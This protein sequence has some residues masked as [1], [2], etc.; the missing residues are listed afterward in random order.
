MSANLSLAIRG[1]LRAYAEA[2]AK[3]A[4]RI[5]TT[6]VRRAASRTAKG[7]QRQ[8]KSAFEDQ[9]KGGRTL[10]NAIR[11]KSIP[12]SG[13]S[14]DTVARVYSKAKYGASNNR[15]RAAFDLASL[16]ETAGTVFAATKTWLAIPTGQAPQRGGQG[17]SRQAQPSESGL[18]L[19]FVP[20][21]SFRALLV[22]DDPGRPRG[23][24]PVVMYVLVKQS[25]RRR[26]LDPGRAH[27]QSL[28][29]SFSDFQQLWARHDAELRARFGRGLET[30]NE[31]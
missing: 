11:W 6:I 2:D 16:Y 25:R 4:E 19:R 9:S 30:L 26:R 12:R 1:D 5:H 17:G 13:F 21:S 31:D 14:T 28:A 8:I 27:D 23:L 29:R 3:A 7:W 15:R 22:R 10:A 18:K 20:I 24:R